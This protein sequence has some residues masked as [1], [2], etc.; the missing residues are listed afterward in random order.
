ME[1]AVTKSL[2]DL[3]QEVNS[4]GSRAS[5][6]SVMVPE[7]Q[8]EKMLLSKTSGGFIADYVEIPE[9][10]I[11]IERAV[12]QVEKS[13]KAKQELKEEKEELEA[14]NKKSSKP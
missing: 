10:A 11:E 6:D 4:I 3:G 8:E 13:L 2:W 7:D 1:A 12:W 9:L 5:N 14:A